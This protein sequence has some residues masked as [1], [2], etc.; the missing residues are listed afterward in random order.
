[1]VRSIL[2]GGRRRGW[3]V[4]AVFSEVARNKVWLSELRGEGF[5]CRLAPTGR[6]SRGQI[7]KQ[8]IATDEPLIAHTHFATFD[9]PAA[10]AAR[11]NDSV[12][13][14][15]HK[16]GALRSEAQLRNTVK[17]GLLS[18]GVEEILCVAPNV[19]SDAR[20]C[21]APRDRLA[22]V[23]NVIDLARFP[24]A[25]PEDRRK[26]RETLALPLDAPII[27]HFGWDWQL[28]GGDI[29]L[30]A[31]ASLVRREDM[32]NLLA[33][34]VADP[35]PVRALAESL[36]IADR[37]RALAPRDDVQTLYAAADVFAAPSRTEGHP[38]AVAEALASG[39][40]IVASPMAGHELIAES[41]QAC[42]IAA[43]DPRAFADAISATLALPAADRERARSV[44]RARIVND[45]DI[46]A[47]SERMLARYEQALERRSS[48]SCPRPPWGRAPAGV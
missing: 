36:G 47:W 39:L 44:D 16:H 42:R 17:L 29:L 28:K 11:R 40:P 43:L 22:L 31:V 4:E 14:Y 46:G 19:L 25:T 24:L 27:L 2:D 32:S 7:V 10:A 6:R 3:N 13:A 26:A 21:L 23:P 37:V 18:R 45:M 48:V 41:A 34:T 35:Q 12:I 9:L 5:V 1:M 38:F 30:E 20:R 8:L 33:V 15:W